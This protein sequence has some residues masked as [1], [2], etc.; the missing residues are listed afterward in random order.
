MNMMLWFAN[1]Q[2]KLIL[3]MKKKIK[4]RNR[5]YYLCIHL[6]IY[7][8][9]NNIKKHILIVIILFMFSL[10]TY[11]FIIYNNNIQY[12][13]TESVERAYYNV[14]SKTSF[15][16]RTFFLKLIIYCC[17]YSTNSFILFD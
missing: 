8:I 10:I 15:S 9:Y 6:I 4:Y 11:T 1:T 3:I 5:S 17:W 2:H 14:G 12:I 16:A 13:Y 7:T